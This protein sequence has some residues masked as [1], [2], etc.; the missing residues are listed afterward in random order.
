MVGAGT[1]DLGVP[2]FQLGRGDAALLGNRIATITRLN[3]VE[4]ITVPYNARLK[5]RVARRG[6][7]GSGS[8][9]GISTRNVDTDIVIRPKVRAGGINLSIPGLELNRGDAVLLGNSI[10]TVAG[11]DCVEKVTVFYNSRHCGGIA[12]V[13][14]RARDSRSSHSSGWSGRRRCWFGRRDRRRRRR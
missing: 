9:R 10:T 3:L 14:T 12:R 4:A 11:L 8:G 5:G 13:D 1:V 7:G 2:A 6:T